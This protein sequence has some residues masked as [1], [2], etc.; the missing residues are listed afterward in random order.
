M[1][2]IP[3]TPDGTWESERII[4]HEVSDMAVCDIDGDGE[5]ELATIAALVASKDPVT[6]ASGGERG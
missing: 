6:L 4:G 2:Y 1:L 3:Q 5:L